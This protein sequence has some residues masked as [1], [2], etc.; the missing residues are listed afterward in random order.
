MPNMQLLHSNASGS[1][2]VVAMF[3]IIQTKTS[4]ACVFVGFI[5][6]V[7]GI[8][9]RFVVTKRECSHSDENNSLAYPTVMALN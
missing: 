8:H 6:L 7:V 1:Y 3:L 9:A 2:L 5:Y 4:R